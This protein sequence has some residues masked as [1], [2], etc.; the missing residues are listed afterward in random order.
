MG[1]TGVH[2][3]SSSYRKLNFTGRPELQTND[4]KWNETS[5]ILQSPLIKAKIVGGAL[6]KV[7]RLI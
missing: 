3:A 5:D 2:A 1:S 6:I 7:C 4:M